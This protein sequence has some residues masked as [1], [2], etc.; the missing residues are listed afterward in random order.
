MRKQLVPHAVKELAAEVDWLDLTAVAVEITSEDPSRPIE[1]ALLGGE[2]EGWR[3]NEPG[4]QTIRLMF[5]RPQD[6]RRI[7]L[8]FVETTVP[9]TQEL[10][11]RWA[12]EGSALREIVRQQWNFSPDGATRETE[13]YEVQLSGA[14]V[15]EL[16]L[17]P[18]ISG[19]GGYASLQRLRLG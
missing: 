10:V 4:V 15:L 1:G 8:S 14:K 2:A 6:V 5:D 12:P 16:M 3:A 17:N 18:D 9:R 13:D 11:L 19:G 7:H